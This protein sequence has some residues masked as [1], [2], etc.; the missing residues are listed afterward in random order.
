MKKCVEL[1]VSSSLVRRAKV[2]DDSTFFN[3]IND[4]C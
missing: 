4:A 1:P 2:S 3:V